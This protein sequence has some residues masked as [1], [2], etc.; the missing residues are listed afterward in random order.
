MAGRLRLDFEKLPLIEVALRVSISPPPELTI[1]T[2]Y[3]VR[4]ELGVAYTTIETPKQLE[5]P[6]GIKSEL[7]FGPTVFAGADFSGH[8]QGIRLSMQRQVVVA[9]WVQQ[10]GETSPKYPRYGALESSLNDGMAALA[11]ALGGGAITVSAVNLSYINFIEPNESAAA[12]L[13]YFSRLVQTEATKDAKELHKIE[14]AWRRQ[15]DV[16][17]RFQLEHVNAKL[18]GESRP[19]FRLTTIAGK[20]LPTPPQDF[21]APLSEVHNELQLFFNELL[22]AKAKAEWQLR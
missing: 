6:P 20:M 17:L 2:I 1:Q 5:A 11:K 10:F 7:M 9:R 3:S 15:D 13:E 22:S 18:L 14:L 12:P 16:D 21:S 8:K 4:E 19:G